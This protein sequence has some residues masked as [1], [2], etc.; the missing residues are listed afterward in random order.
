MESKN[1]GKRAY[2]THRTKQTDTYGSEH[3]Y[4]GGRG[5]RDERSDWDWHTSAA[6]RTVNNKDLSYSMGNSTQY[7]ETNHMG[8]E[9]KEE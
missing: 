7:S 3:G 8:K 1:G 5:W 4:C 9:S 6:M 2:D